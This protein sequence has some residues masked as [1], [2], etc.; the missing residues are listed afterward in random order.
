PYRR[1]C[2]LPHRRHG[3]MPARRHYGADCAAPPPFFRRYGSENQARTAPP[4]GWR[5]EYPADFVKKPDAVPARGFYG[6]RRLKYR[7]EYRRR[8]Y[9]A[10]DGSTF[11]APSPCRRKTAP[12]PY[13]AD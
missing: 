1:D 11:P 8:G 3:T 10:P 12:L 13:R 5:R 9:A 4:D 2:R 7:F 6:R